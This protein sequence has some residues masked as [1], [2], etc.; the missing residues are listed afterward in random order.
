MFVRKSGIF[1]TIKSGVI[2]FFFEKQ[3]KFLSAE[4]FLTD[5]FHGVSSSSVFKNIIGFTEI[6]CRANVPVQAGCIKG[7]GAG[8]WGGGL[9]GLLG[10]CLFSCCRVSLG[11][12]SAK[13]KEDLPYHRGCGEMK[14]PEALARPGD[15]WPLIRLLQ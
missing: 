6:G 10:R 1:E 8:G 12:S 2:F 13:H 15:S 3:H 9:E 7:S 14:E 5:L 4:R 11:W